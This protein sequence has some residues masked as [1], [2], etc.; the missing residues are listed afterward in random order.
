M[1]RLR[2]IFYWGVQD[3]M[4]ITKQKI[5]ILQNKMLLMTC[6]VLCM[7]FGLFLFLNFWI[8]TVVVVFNLVAM[9]ACLFLNKKGHFLISKMVFS[10]IAVLLLIMSVI[11]KRNGETLSLEFVIA[12]RNGIALLSILVLLLSIYEKPIKIFLVCLPGLISIIF[13]E[14]IHAFFG[15]YNL[16]DLPIKNEF[17]FRL[18]PIITFLG[19]AGALWALQDVSMIFEKKIRQLL[20]LTAEKNEEL[21]IQNEIIEDKNKQITNSI[22]YAQRIQQAILGDQNEIRQYFSE[23]F[24]FFQPRNIV[25]GDFYWFSS[26]T[27]H[28]TVLVAADCTG[29]GVPG[30]FMT[31]MGAN[32]LDE[33]INNQ[34][35][36]KPS[37]ILKVLDQKVISSTNRQTSE[38]KVNDGMD[39]V[40]VKIDTHAQKAYFS[41]AKNSLYLVRNQEIKEIKGS[42]SPIGSLQFKQ[43]KIF[44]TV[45]I[46]L[47]KGD[48]LY[49]ASDGFQD[50]FGGTE[51]RKYMTKRFRELLLTISILP[52][53]QQDEKLRSVWQDWKGNLAQ[54]DDILVIG[55]KI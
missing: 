36:R 5:I 15:I 45:E 35:L 24:V 52:M 28:E 54:T 17:V 7:L 33:I 53:H 25:S 27:P 21:K 8:N 26:I 49:L 19:V 2:E 44:E 12:P 43:E 50:Q 55:V 42:K 18:I 14:E 37:E 13:F 4:P 22:Q 3:E 46:D 29:H 31:V 32:F 34:G 6:V 23:S 39:L 47:E 40:L 20:S 10:S 1:Q 41:G 51:K 11:S 48:I 38:Q 30:A 16:Y 9:I